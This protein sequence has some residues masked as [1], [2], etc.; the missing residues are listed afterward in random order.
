MRKFAL[1]LSFLLVVGFCGNAWSYD[2]V[3]HVS[4]APNLK[5]DVLIYPVYFT[6]DGWSTKFTVINTSLTQSVVAKVI[7]RSMSRS[8][9]LLDFFIY[10]SPTDVWT[11]T[12]Y[13][14]T[15]DNRVY[16]TSEDDSVNN[17]S[18]GMSFASPTD[19]L[20]ISLVDVCPGDIA[21]VG[22]V[23]VIE[24]WSAYLGNPPVAKSLIKGVYQTW[25]NTGNIA[26]TTVLY[27]GTTY[28]IDLPI[29]VLTGSEEISN[30][31]NG[32]FFSLNATVLK[33]YDSW[34]RMTVTYET[35]LGEDANNTLTEVEAALAKNNLAIPYYTGSLG[36]TM[37][38][39]TF[40]TKLAGFAN[41][42]WGFLGTYSGFYN[43]PFTLTAFDL[44]ENTVVITTD[45]S[46]VV[47]SSNTFPFEVNQ[48]LASDFSSAIGNFTEGWMLINMNSG[49]S[50][51]STR[52][53]LGCLDITYTGA[54]AIGHSMRFYSAVN[55]GGWLYNAH[56]QG[57][58][59]INGVGQT[60]YQYFM[61][62]DN[63]TTFVDG[64]TAH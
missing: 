63:T 42:T 44:E 11:G 59:T 53:C 24:A 34:Q 22:Y 51:G 23:E 8:Q 12:I 1:V 36:Y 6:G 47:I 57:A 9:E 52:S 18:G 31:Y 58:V 50:T 5:G 61:Q 7:F 32:D 3:D 28:N 37:A 26:P 17:N 55:G 14:N 39:V 30:S 20:D 43:V 56:D 62:N 25:F 60:Q 41:C 21:T 46:P 29:N 19:P 4:I 10:L 64:S 16:V 54:P 35:K 33:N 27:S 49:A 13:Q 48:I 15:S 38:V 40:P 45:F 2:D